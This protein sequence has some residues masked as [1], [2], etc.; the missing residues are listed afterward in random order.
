VGLD[1]DVHLFAGRNVLD[2][3]DDF[4]FAASHSDRV[5]E[6]IEHAPRAIRSHLVL[7]TLGIGHIYFNIKHI[8]SQYIY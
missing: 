2:R 8:I 5:V 1:G 4:S 7:L 3:I 6:I